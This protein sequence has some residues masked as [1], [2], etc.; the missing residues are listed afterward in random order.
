MSSTDVTD[1]EEESQQ[2]TE[3][4]PQPST[5]AQ[6]DVTVPPTPAAVHCLRHKLLV[7]KNRNGSRSSSSRCCSLSLLSMNKG[8]RNHCC[9]RFKCLRQSNWWRDLYVLLCVCWR[10]LSF[11][12]WTTVVNLCTSIAVLIQKNTLQ[13]TVSHRQQT[14]YA[15]KFTPKILGH[16]TLFPQLDYTQ[17]YWPRAPVVH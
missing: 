7:N 16:W 9:S 8:T 15:P 3:P 2:E 13:D 12:L 10:M 11:V 14:P 1:V 4:Q 17:K 6:P 5:S